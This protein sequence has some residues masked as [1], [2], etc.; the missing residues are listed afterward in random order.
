VGVVR[1]EGAGG[2]VLLLLLLLLLLV[3]LGVVVRGEVVV[4]LQASIGVSVRWRLWV[5]RVGAVLGRGRGA[6]IHRIRH[7][8]GTGPPPPPPTPTAPP[9]R[10]PPAKGRRTGGRG[11]GHGG[12]G[13]AHPPPPLAEPLWLVV[14]LLVDPLELVQRLTEAP[15]RGIQLWWEGGHR[16]SGQVTTQAGVTAAR[17]QRL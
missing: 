13:K 4:A 11:A 1:G 8:A 5:V 2:G 10:T 6:H 7:R 9:Q 16:Q 12:R 14:L 3:L 17:S 15:A